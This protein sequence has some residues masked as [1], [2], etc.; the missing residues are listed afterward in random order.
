MVYAASC[1]FVFCCWCVQHDTS[2]IVDEVTAK[3]P[4]SND[5]VCTLHMDSELST[6]TLNVI[7]VNNQ[8]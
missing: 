7:F 4:S 1:R 5:Q 2:E 6:V 3:V 8:S